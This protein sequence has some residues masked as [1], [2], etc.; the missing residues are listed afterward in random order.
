MDVDKLESY[1]SLDKRIWKTKHARYLASNRLKKRNIWSQYTI[2]ILSVYVLALSIAPKY[3]Y[4][5]DI[6][7]DKINFIN[8]ILSIC[9]IVVS[10]LE[11]NNGYQLQSERLFNCANELNGLL[12]QLKSGRDFSDDIS[13]DIQTVSKQYE[14]ILHKYGENHTSYDF[15]LFKAMNPSDFQ[16]DGVKALLIPYYYIK[17]YT[18]SYFMYVFF[19]LSPI[20]LIYGSCYYKTL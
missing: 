6:S 12:Q 2:S 18:C 3:S 15:D 10:L 7:P 11:A 19:I 13:K 4:F 16:L 20:A 14:A 5:T 17:Y 1:N 8:I 9:I